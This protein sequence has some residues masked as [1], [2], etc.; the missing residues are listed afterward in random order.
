ML[1]GCVQF[2]PERVNSGFTSIF[3][4]KKI[5]APETRKTPIESGFFGDIS[6]LHILYG[7]PSEVKSELIAEFSISS[8]EIVLLPSL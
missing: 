8:I 1:S 6:F 3:R 2:L 4:D 5:H 7:A